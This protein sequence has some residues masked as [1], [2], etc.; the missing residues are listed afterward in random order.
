MCYKLQARS[1]KWFPVERD[2]T[3]FNKKYAKGF[4]L[5]VV[6]LFYEVPIALNYLVFGR[7]DWSV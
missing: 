2:M 6:L 7:K 4:V 1:H 3:A 5:F